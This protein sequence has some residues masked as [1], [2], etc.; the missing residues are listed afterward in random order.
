MW[1]E[2]FIRHITRLRSTFSRAFIN[3]KEKKRISNLSVSIIDLKSSMVFRKKETRRRSSKEHRGNLTFNLSSHNCF[4]FQHAASQFC[5]KVNRT[6]IITCDERSRDLALNHESTNAQGE[7]QKITKLRWEY[8]LHLRL[9][10]LICSNHREHLFLAPFRG[11]H[12]F[13]NQPKSVQDG[14]HEDYKEQ[15]FQQFSSCWWW[16]L[17][18]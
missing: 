18:F 2:S 10:D 11:S 1:N 3:E 4:F 6:H 9:I 16:L 15:K 17:S 5:G 8:S 14:D 13:F 7:A 12:L